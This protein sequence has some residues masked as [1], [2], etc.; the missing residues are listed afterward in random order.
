M[1]LT[2]EEELSHKEG[3]F[4]T[5]FESQGWNVNRYLLIFLHS[6]QKM[7]IFKTLQRSFFAYVNEFEMK[8]DI[9]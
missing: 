4:S 2:T 8:L 5:Y 6:L 3:S 1:T 9:F 7:E